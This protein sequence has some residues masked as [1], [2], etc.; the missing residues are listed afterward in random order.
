MAARLPDTLRL[1]RVPADSIPTSWRA[2]PRIH[3]AAFID[4][5][6]LAEAAIENR[7]LDPTVVVSSGPPF[8]TFI[9]GYYAARYFNVPLVLDYRD[10]WSQC[11]Y[12]W[13]S[14][15]PRD[16]IWDKRIFRSANAAVFTT[17]SQL[18]KTVSAHGF[19]PPVCT[20][21]ANGWDEEDFEA[22][23]LVQEPASP[24]SAISF[25]GHLNGHPEIVPFLSLAQRILSRRTDLAARLEFQFVGAGDAR[26]DQVLA[27]HPL[28]PSIRRRQ[29][30][31]KREALSMMKASAALLI[32]GD[33]RLSIYIPGKL[34]DY[35]ASRRPVLFYGAE[36]EV[37]RILRGLRAGWVVGPD[38]E[39]QL[40]AALDEIVSRNSLQLSGA[41]LDAWLPLH[42]RG[43]LAQA[44][45][46]VVEEVLTPRTHV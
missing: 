7:E 6:R 32:V 15:T 23:A 9:A 25:I 17:R 2:F 41:E 4:G 16:R 11:P 27:N 19:R 39:S 26:F 33:E 31:P 21:I 37:T 22:S 24:L 18:E 35:L 13:Y 12:G 14:Q 40:E 10:V 44:F 36:G 29:H 38:S 42:S 5:L 46:S 34:Y 1:Y 28:A 45:F 43:A 20:V 30:V 3:D 8:S